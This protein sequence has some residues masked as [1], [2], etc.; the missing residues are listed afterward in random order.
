[1]KTKK[2]DDNNDVREMI[3]LQTIANSLVVTVVQHHY[4]QH[5]HG[6]E[7]KQTMTY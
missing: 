4:H 3:L 2:D 6:Q 7:H 1:M 5:Q